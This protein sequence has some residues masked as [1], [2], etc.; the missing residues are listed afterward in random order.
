MLFFAVVNRALTGREKILGAE[1]TDTLS[2]V[3]NLAILL[4]Q[5]GDFVAARQM[6]E[7]AVDGYEKAL[8]PMHR[9]TLSTVNNLAI[10]LKQQGELQVAMAQ[11][12]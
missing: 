11:L 7:R 2:T 3:N 1:H 5:Q 8:G 10:L 6:Y 9:N 4:K 12:F